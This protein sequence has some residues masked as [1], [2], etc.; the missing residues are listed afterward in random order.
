M[1]WHTSY[2]RGKGTPNHCVRG[3]VRPLHRTNMTRWVAAGEEYDMR[4]NFTTLRMR[5]R[6][7]GRLS[8]QLAC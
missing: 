6:M 1:L 8:D 7:P 4:F 2:L 5:N 3:L